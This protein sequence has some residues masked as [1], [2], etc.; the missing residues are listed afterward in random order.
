MEEIGWR[1][2]RLG[3]LDFTPP[4]LPSVPP[5]RRDRL[6]RQT[7]DPP[8]EERRKPTFDAKT[9]S[10]RNIKTSVSSPRILHRATPYTLPYVSLSVSARHVVARL[11]NYTSFVARSS[12]L[13]KCKPSVPRLLVI[14]I[15]SLC[16]HSSSIGCLT[17]SKCGKPRGRRVWLEDF[18]KRLMVLVLHV[19]FLYLSALLA[20]PSRIP[21]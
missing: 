8:L 1:S 3:I 19:W 17:K 16:W 9:P 7:R 21:P 18:A 14:S 5:R 10:G 2:R 15:Q 13:A 20:W 11:V 6:T 12:H 4:G